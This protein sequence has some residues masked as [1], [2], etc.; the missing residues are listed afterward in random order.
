[1]GGRQDGPAVGT[2]VGHIVVRAGVQAV[3]EEVCSA[4]G[5]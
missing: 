3:V 5:Q 2:A 1:M 4:M